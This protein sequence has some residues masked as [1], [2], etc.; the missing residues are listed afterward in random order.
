MPNFAICRIESKE[1][2]TNGAMYEASDCYA[3]F[4]GTIVLQVANNIG[5]C[6]TISIKNDAFEFLFNTLESDA[7]QYKGM[8]NPYRKKWMAGNRTATK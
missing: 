4:N 7:Q 5:D 1:N 2:Y 3:T 6:E 8:T